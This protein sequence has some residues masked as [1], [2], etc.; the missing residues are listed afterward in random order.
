MASVAAI[1]RVGRAIEPRNQSKRRQVWHDE[2][3]RS[4][5]DKPLDVEGLIHAGI[6]NVAL[7]GGVDQIVRASPHNEEC[8]RGDLRMGREVVGDLLADILHVD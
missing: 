2:L 6:N 7:R 5:I 8:L 3:C 4:G 1:D